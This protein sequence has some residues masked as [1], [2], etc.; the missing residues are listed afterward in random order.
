MKI[1]SDETLFFALYPP[2]VIRSIFLPIICRAMSLIVETMS[3]N[4]K[5]SSSY[6]LSL[7]QIYHISLQR[8]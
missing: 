7:P 4:R 2:T 1:A 8:E 3:E 6:L 5:S